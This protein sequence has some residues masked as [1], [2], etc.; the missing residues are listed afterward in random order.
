MRII[1]TGRV[2]AERFRKLDPLHVPGVLVASHGPFAWGA[3][4]GKAVE[5]AVVLEFLARLASE[6]LRA[7]PRLKPMPGALL[8][9]HFSRKH[10]PHACYGQQTTLASPALTRRLV[11]EK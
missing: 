2:I 4:V 7:N 1:F 10:G 8:E 3:T 11:C 6:T 9:K 5:H